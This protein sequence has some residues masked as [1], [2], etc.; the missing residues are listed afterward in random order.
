MVYITVKQSP[1]YHQITL[2]ELLSDSFGPALALNPNLTNTKTYEVENVSEYMARKLRFNIPGLI[3]R[4][5]QFNAMTEHL[6]AVPRHD[7]YREFKI[8]KKSGGWREISAPEP[9][10]MEALRSLKDIFENDFGALYH[11]SAFAY[12]RKR[13][14]LDAMKRHQANESRWYSKYD[15]HDFFGSTTLDFIIKMFSMIY[16][17]SEVVKSE[18]GYNELRKAVELAMLDGGLPQGTP[19]SP[20]I[21]NIMMIPVDYKLS[22][23]LRSYERQNFV[24][25]R[26]ADDFQISSRYDFDY[27]EIESVIKQVL[28]S[29]GAPFTINEK[30]TRYGSSSGRNFNLGLMLCKDQTGKVQI[31]V[32]HEKKR[33]FRAK[34]SSFI[35]D[36]MNGRPWDPHDVQVLEGYRNYLHMIEPEASN[37]IIK[38]AGEKYNVN[39]YQLIKSQLQV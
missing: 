5:K 12:I 36:T 33:I 35:L 6:R 38:K 16:P 8:P 29:F 26:Y 7:L 15:L 27:R 19:I 30:K 1:I 18:E 37:K 22:N 21:T 24:Y 39:V 9:Q 25:T 34:L 20:M 17:F 3:G 13:S 31:T 2:D 32:G 28:A 11:T 4:L 23:K 10:L 14:T